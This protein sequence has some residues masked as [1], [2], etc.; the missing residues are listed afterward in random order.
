MQ[1]WTMGGVA[2]RVAIVATF[3]VVAMLRMVGKETAG[4]AIFVGA[5]LKS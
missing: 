3:S 5:K 1:F 4:C 2:G